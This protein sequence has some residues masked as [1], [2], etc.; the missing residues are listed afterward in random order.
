MRHNVSEIEAV[1]RD[2]RTVPPEQYSDR[3]VHREIVEQILTNATWAP[4]HG[5]TQPWRFTVFMGGSQ[6]KMA[7]VMADLYRDTAGQD[8]SEARAQ[9]LEA[10][11]E[12]ASVIIILGLDHDAAGRF[13]EWEDRAALAA[14][15][16][17]M[18]LTATAQGLGALWSTP[19]FIA[20]QGMRELMAWGDQVQCAGVFYLG[21]PVGDWPKGHRKPL[22]Y[23][24]RWVAD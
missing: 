22:E 4:N 14:A 8:A 24:T 6:K 19:A 16:Q 5:L 12:K 1:I 18:Y 9:K 15:V 7:A 21:Y 10:R 13:P 11:G 17:N 2:R 23:V 3:K 20:S